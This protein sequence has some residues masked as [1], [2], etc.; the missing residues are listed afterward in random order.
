[1]NAIAAVKLEAVD[2]VC[3]PASTSEITNAVSHALKKHA[4]QLRQRHMKIV[5]NQAL[6]AL[7]KIESVPAALS[8]SKTS[9]PPKPKLKSSAK[10][11]ISV[12]PLKL[13]CR[14][15][16]VVINDDSDQLIQLTKGEMAV[17]AGMMAHPNQV[18][19]CQ[20]LVQA[21]WGYEV[22]ETEAES[23]IRPY[24]SRLRRKFKH[25]EVTAQLIHTIRRRGYCFAAPLEPF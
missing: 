2:Y 6:D 7:N 14:K 22:N 25:N 12:F 11:I 18:L 8:T 16:L 24:I 19:S 9:S 15:R 13:D 3:K 17:L 21:A 1:E 10:Q 23:V 20:Q 5:L 4:W